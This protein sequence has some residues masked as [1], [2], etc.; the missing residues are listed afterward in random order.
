[1]NVQWLRKLIVNDLKYDVPTI[2]HEDN[3]SVIKLIEGDQHT[4]QL[5]RHVD[6]KYFSK[7]SY[8]TKR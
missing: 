2:I 7:R 4:Q 8:I 3:R 1:M 6:V 5:T